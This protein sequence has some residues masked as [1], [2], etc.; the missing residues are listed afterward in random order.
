MFRILI[1]CL[2]LFWLHI[3]FFIQ[4]R[5]CSLFFNLSSICYRLGLGRTK[6]QKNEIA[7]STKYSKSLRSIKCKRKAR[8]KWCRNH[9][10]AWVPKLYAVCL[11]VCVWLCGR[12]FFFPYI[13]TSPRLESKQF[14]WYQ[15]SQTFHAGMQ[16][17]HMQK[18]I[19]APSI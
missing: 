6:A 15:L 11:F 14:Y 10:V 17:I 5:K 8:T 2:F 1:L 7:T 4:T 3:Q 9:L 19:V 12:V 18:K 16:G 13:F